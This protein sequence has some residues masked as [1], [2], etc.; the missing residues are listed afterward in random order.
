[1]M[2]AGLTCLLVAVILAFVT[3]MP[4][5]KRA[6]RVVGVFLLL[7]SVLVLLSAIALSWSLP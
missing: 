4:A 2:S 1:M 7:A 6:K 5:T 3:P